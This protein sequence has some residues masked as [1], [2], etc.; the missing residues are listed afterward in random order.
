MPTLPTASTTP[1]D[2]TLTYV[3]ALAQC[4]AQGVVDN[5]LTANNEL[6]D[7]ANALLAP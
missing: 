5:L 6:A 1:L 7:C 4:T 2:Q 3:Q